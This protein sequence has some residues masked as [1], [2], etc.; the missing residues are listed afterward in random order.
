MARRVSRLPDGGAVSGGKACLRGD[1]RV[2]ATDALVN[3]HA[4]AAISCIPLQEISARPE[5]TPTNASSHQAVTCMAGWV[6]RPYLAA[7]RRSWSSSSDNVT[8]QTALAGDRV[9]A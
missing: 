4:P 5:V 3:R 1:G 6:L 7:A 8:T 9:L 2:F